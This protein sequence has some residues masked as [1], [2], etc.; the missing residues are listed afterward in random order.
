MN[1]LIPF[2]GFPKECF[3]FFREI[4]KNNNRRW[5]E[6]HKAEYQEVVLAPAQAFVTTLG[7]RLRTLSKEVR[8]D[9]RTSGTG[10]IRRIYRDTRFSKDKTPYKTH[11]GIIF[12]QGLRKSKTD[13]P[14]YFFHLDPHGAKVFAGMYLFPPALLGAYRSAVADNRLGREL[15]EGLESV[16]KRSGY[17]VADIHY[18]RVPSGYAPDHPRADLLRYNAV[19]AISPQVDK[20]TAMTPKL[21][22]VCFKH[23]RMMAPLNDWISKVARRVR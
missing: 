7:H 13:N 10:S 9:P 8:F 20:A 18:K 23:C 3:R 1:E 4:S 16:R 12:W 6:D 2:S 14:G 19:Y 11:L 5:F 22:D 21:V 17:K 15:I